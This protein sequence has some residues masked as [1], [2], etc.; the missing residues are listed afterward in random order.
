[1][2]ELNFC[3]VMKTVSLEEAK[4]MFPVVHQGL[5]ECPN[6][7][8]AGGDRWHN[9][10]GSEWGERCDRCAGFG[11]IP[12][13]RRHGR[14]KPYTAAGIKRLPCARC[15]AKA[16]SQWQVCADNRLYRP[17]C[18]AC[19]VDLNRMVLFWMNDPQA[20]EKASTYA[21]GGGA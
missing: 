12:E 10:D 21:A 14:E 17:L 19:D 15:G 13:F 7:R 4:A 6:C 20:E 18:T 5:V 2:N 9:P 1:V 8:G 16:S 3:A 11:H